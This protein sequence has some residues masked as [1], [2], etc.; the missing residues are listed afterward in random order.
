MTKMDES[1]RRR[2]EGSIFRHNGYWF[3]TY[4]YT[5]DGKQRKKK[6]CL[7]PIENFKSESAV[8]SEAKRARDQFITDLKSGKVVAS[9]AES[10]TCGEL[11]TQYAAHLKAQKKPA[12]Y[13]IE[14]CIEANIRP[15]F[16]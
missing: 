13:V 7:G 12:A 10:V 16:G 11:L 2:G 6:K 3:Y 14:K 9:D 4:G 5:I 15:F 8:W 1:R